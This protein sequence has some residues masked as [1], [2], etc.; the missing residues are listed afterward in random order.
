[1]QETKTLWGND[2][3]PQ[4]LIK[5]TTKNHGCY[6]KKGE[7]GEKIPGIKS[8]ITKCK[9]IGKNSSGT[10]PRYRTRDKVKGKLEVNLS[11]NI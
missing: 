9:R 2:K 5:T 4:I 1:M 10:L 6:K 8:I 3:Q 11:F 7:M